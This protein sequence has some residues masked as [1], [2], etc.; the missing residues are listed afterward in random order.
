M[1]G[2]GL[3]AACV[4]ATCCFASGMKVCAITG[5]AEPAQ[6][7]RAVADRIASGGKVLVVYFSVPETD[8]VDASSGA[9]RVNAGG[10]VQGNT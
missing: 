6:L 4:A 5:A 1:A 10:K 3:V 9:S 2:V 7:Q 8:G